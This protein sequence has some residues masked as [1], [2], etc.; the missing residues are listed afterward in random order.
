M[1]TIEELQ[2]RIAEL[3]EEVR[4]LR[5]LLIPRA[6]D[7]P[8][9]SGRRMIRLS[10]LGAEENAKLAVKVFEEMGIHGEP[11]GAAR[12]REM[13]IADGIKPEDNIASRG[14]IEMRE[15]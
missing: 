7:T 1:P 4:D 14:I 2:K 15:E 9:E 13:M 8:A 11:I 3:E 5:W 6:D 10:Q 12:V